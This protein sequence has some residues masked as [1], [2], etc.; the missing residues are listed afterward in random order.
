MQYI[1]LDK[2]QESTGYIAFS[3]NIVSTS[4]CRLYTYR[5]GKLYAVSKMASVDLA[6]QKIT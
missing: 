4:I 2:W 6:P 1:H 5:A 3:N